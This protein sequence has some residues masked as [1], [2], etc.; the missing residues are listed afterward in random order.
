[1]WHPNVQ[2]GWG[3]R[4]I[5]HGSNMVC[6]GVQNPKSNTNK[7]I[8]KKQIKSKIHLKISL[9]FKH[10]RNI[11]ECVCCVHICFY[12]YVLHTDYLCTASLAL[13]LR[14]KIKCGSGPGP[15]PEVS[16][17][18]LIREVPVVSSPL[19]IWVRSHLRPFPL[20]LF[21]KLC[22]KNSTKLFSEISVS[23]VAWFPEHCCWGGLP[24]HLIHF[25][26]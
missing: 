18:Y 16:L 17:P 24:T 2:G 21:S 8:Q 19:F 22:N 15:G 12:M 25:A 3:P 1:M 23:T 7:W 20:L 5:E 14:L 26:N 4:Q 10:S 11:L 6:C 9:I 13:D